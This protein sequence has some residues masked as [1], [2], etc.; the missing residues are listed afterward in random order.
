[1]VSAPQMSMVL[2]LVLA[3]NQASFGDRNAQT[4]H[5]MKTAVCWL[6]KLSTLGSWV[7][8]GL[9][10]HKSAYCQSGHSII[11]CNF[12]WTI[13]KTALPG[14]WIPVRIST[15]GYLCPDI[16]LFIF[17]QFHCWR[18]QDGLLWSMPAITLQSDEYGPCRFFIIKSLTITPPNTTR[19]A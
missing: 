11:G 2:I 1:M 9:Y 10:P 18:K 19:H 6:H 12:Q 3:G 17:Y 8:T 16:V 4:S 7:C 13:S 14:V 15:A 5:V